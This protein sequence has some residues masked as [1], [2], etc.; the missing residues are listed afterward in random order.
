MRLSEYMSD[1]AKLEGE[2][3]L[4]PF[5]LT[6]PRLIKIILREAITGVGINS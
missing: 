4:D 1:E 3:G 6:L 5:Q 2:R